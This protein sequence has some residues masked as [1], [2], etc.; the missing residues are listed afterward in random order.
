MD[1]DDNPPQATPLSHQRVL[2]TLSAVSTQDAVIRDVIPRLVE[3]AQHLCD[4]TK[5]M[6]C[7]SVHLR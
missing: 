7:V 1:T 4:G 2:D 5:S 3:H 6:K